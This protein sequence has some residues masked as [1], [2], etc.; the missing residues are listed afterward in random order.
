MSRK[1]DNYPKKSQA[2]SH[3]EDGFDVQVY[4]SSV[5][6]LNGLKSVGPQ[7]FIATPNKLLERIAFWKRTIT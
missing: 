1:T 6:K 3:K 7:Y 5:N 4:T 2:L